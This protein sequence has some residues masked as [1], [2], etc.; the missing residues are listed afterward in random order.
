MD[1]IVDMEKKHKQ[2]LGVTSSLFERSQELA[3]QT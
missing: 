2:L 3:N 1:E